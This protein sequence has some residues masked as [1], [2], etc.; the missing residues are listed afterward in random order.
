MIS[1]VV[2]DIEAALGS[3]IPFAGELTV[4]ELTRFDPALNRMNRVCMNQADWGCD[5]LEACKNEMRAVYG[6]LCAAHECGTAVSG[7]RGYS[8]SELVNNS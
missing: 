6:Q 5:E 8:I 1:E 7:N 3:S 4:K 2:A